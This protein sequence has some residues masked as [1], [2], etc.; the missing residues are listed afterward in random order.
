[1]KMRK[2]KNISNGI[3]KVKEQK[4]VSEKRRKRKNRR[5]LINR[6]KR[7]KREELSKGSREQR[8]KVAE[9]RDI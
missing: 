9:Q 4:G 3:R 6:R 2:R 7:A 8:A 1:M 5:K